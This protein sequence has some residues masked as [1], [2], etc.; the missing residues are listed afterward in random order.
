MIPLA[1]SIPQPRLR[2][3]FV[4]ERGLFV[5]PECRN[6]VR[7]PSASTVMPYSPVSTPFR[8]MR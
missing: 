5:H 3:L 7:L 1:G 4:M 2:G 6:V 8:M